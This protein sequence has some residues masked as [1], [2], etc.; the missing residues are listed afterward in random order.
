M[1]KGR[2]HFTG[3]FTSHAVRKSVVDTPWRSDPD[4][5]DDSASQPT[6]VCVNRLVVSEVEGGVHGVNLY[7]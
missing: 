6:T 1:L 7:Q 4:S 3:G 2:G 5:G